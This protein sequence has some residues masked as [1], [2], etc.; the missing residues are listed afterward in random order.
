MNTS[1]DVDEQQHHEKAAREQGMI[2]R[3][4]DAPI[5]Y[6]WSLRVPPF[7]VHSVLAVIMP[8][9]ASLLGLMAALDTNSPT[10]F[11]VGTVLGVAFGFFIRYL[12]MADK[13]YHYQLTPIGI[14]YTTQD[15][16]PEVAYKIVRI[17]AWVGVV[18]CILAVGVLG[19]L[20]FV[21]AGGMALLAFGM[22]NFSSQIRKAHIC[23]VDDFRVNILKKRDMFSLENYPSEC[24][25]SGSIFCKAGEVE[26][27]L[28]KIQSSINI[29]SVKEVKSSRHLFS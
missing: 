19:P 17:F 28:D 6:E 24:Y 27:I 20:A 8:V 4:N 7:F 16:I 22:T 2:Q 18:V 13:H 21:G 15:A 11:F 14:R 26:L 12:W 9:I 10:P 25:Q 5:I 29:T 1:T 23:Y 3:L